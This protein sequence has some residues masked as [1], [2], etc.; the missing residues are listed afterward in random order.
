MTQGL[1]LRLRRPM[2]ELTTSQ[3]TTR[4]DTLKPGLAA[5][6]LLVFVPKWGIKN[7]LWLPSLI[8]LMLAGGAT[9]SQGQPAGG[10]GEEWVT[11]L[12]GPRPIATHKMQAVVL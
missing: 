3:Q 2:P 10:K 8:G 9:N 5:A 4:R 7:K 1:K 6:S 12:E 11:T